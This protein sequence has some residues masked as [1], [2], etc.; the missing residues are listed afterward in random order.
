MV[1]DFDSDI[2]KPAIRKTWKD[3]NIKK[4]AVERDGVIGKDGIQEA[5]GLNLAQA[6][7]YANYNGDNGNNNRGFDLRDFVQKNNK[8]S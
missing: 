1:F 2:I 4:Q 5:I 6:I 8:A 3:N 7:K